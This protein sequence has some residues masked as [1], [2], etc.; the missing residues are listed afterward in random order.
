MRKPQAA[1]M[2]LCITAAILILTPLTPGMDGAGQENPL[3]QKKIQHE[4][5]VILKLVQP[6]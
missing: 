1:G 5:T 4:S 3:I 6:M 2:I